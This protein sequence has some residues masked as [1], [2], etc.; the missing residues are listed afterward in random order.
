MWLRIIKLERQDNLIIDNNIVD[1]PTMNLYYY[2]FKYRNLT[3]IKYEFLNTEL[4]SIE[5]QMD[6]D[7]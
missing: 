4:L 7:K 5:N 2:N 6:P 1:L 3:Q